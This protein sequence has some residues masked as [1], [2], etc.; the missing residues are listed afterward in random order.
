MSRLDHD[1]FGRRRC[2]TILL[3]GLVTTLFSATRAPAQNAAAIYVMKVDGSGVYKL[4]EAPGFKGMGHA[5]WSHDGQR[6]AFHAWDGP[7][8]A[9]QIFVVDVRPGQAPQPWSEGQFPNWSPDDKQLAFQLLTGNTDQAETWVENLDGQGRS[10]LV[11]GVAPRWSPDGG[12]LAFLLNPNLIVRD[13]VSETQQPLLDNSW[14][15]IRQ[16]FDWSPNGNHIAF[17]ARRNGKLGLWIVDVQNLDSSP[18]PRLRLQGDL[19]GQLSWS[20]DGK[21][22]AVTYDS[23]ICLLD[24]DGTG[25]PRRVAGQIGNSRD[26]D[27]SPDGKWIVFSSNRPSE[28]R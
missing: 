27:W 18:E 6:V 16:G 5:R 28:D 25:A 8:P 9:R 21:Q 10:F 15:G 19:M 20:P 7:T 22:L 14:D 2:C 1:R 13:L 11:D 3:L 17:V 24:V 23:V 26:P 4:A 12:R